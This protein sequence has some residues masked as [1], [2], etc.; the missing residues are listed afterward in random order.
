MPKHHGHDVVHA[1]KAMRKGEIGVFFCLGG[2]FISASPDTVATAEGL[3]KVNLTIQVSTKLN[4]A[5]CITGKEALILPCLGRTELDI[6]KEGEQFVSVENSMSIV[7]SSR[8]GFRP[9]STHLR[10]EPWIVA[11]LANATLGDKHLNWLELTDNYDTIRNLMEKSLDGFEDYNLRIR[12]PNG[13]SLP[14]PPRDSQS[15]ATDNGK[16]HFTT[17]SLPNV[18]IDEDKY[19][20][21]TIRSHDQYNTTIYDLHDRYRG[22]HGNRRVVMM[23]AN[24]MIERGW[25]TRTIVDIVS[26]FNGETRKAD[27]WIVIP[28]DIPSGNIATYFPEANCLVP[29]ESTADISNT[30]TSKWVVVSLHESNSSQEE[31]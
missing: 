5:H 21:M 1:I 22:I 14:N 17:N 13:F 4:R 9:A 6:T 10:S 30:P 29:L 26:H 18:S 19:V 3:Q 2:N 24:D 8:G 27:Q 16:A 7:H 31:E 25:K 23:N 15:F 12:N 28:Y 11:Q 20:M